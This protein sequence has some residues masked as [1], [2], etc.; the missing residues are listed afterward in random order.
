MYFTIFTPTYNRGDVL[1]RLYESIK[2]QNFK[3]FEWIIVDDGST[4]NTSEILEKI[5]KNENSIKIKYIKKENGGKHTAINLGV[6][7]AKG[8]F[9]FIVDSDDYLPEDALSIIFE[10]VEQIK[11]NRHYAGVAGL[12]GSNANNPWNNFGTG[13]QRTKNQSYLDKEYIDATS[14]EYRYKYKILG[15]RAEV[16]RTSILKKHPL[17]SYADEKF[18]TEG[19]LWS[20]LAHEGYL[21]RWFNKV[22]YITEEYRNDGLTKNISEIHRKSPKGVREYNNLLASCQE[23]PFFVRFKAGVKYFEFGKYTT[24]GTTELFKNFKWKFMLLPCFI[25][26]LL[27]SK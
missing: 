20:S 18:M 2:L 5:T 4:D 26:S 16:V 19:V 12:R 21:F 6:K 11:N 22:V 25:V 13:K 10:Y 17:P 23:L 8:D 9:F 27:R 3:D 1:Y 7:V 15:D 24:N 14:F